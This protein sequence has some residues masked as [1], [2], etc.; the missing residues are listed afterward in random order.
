MSFNSTVKTIFKKEFRESIY[1]E[2][3]TKEKGSE[4]V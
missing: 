3:D 2:T 4:F 1:D